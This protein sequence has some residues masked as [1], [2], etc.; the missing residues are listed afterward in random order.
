MLINKLFLENYRLFL[1]KEIYFK[2]NLNFIVGNNSTGKTT[3]LESI[4]FAFSGNLIN[5]YNP[6]NYN[7]KNSVI[8]IDFTFNGVINHLQI[9]LK[10]VN[11]KFDRNIYLNDKKVE[12]LR[13]LRDKFLSPIILN[14][15]DISIPTQDPSKKRSFLD[16]FLKIVDEKF[17]KIYNDLKFLNKQKSSILKKNLEMD[18]LKT[19]NQKI[20]EYS[21]YITYKRIEL[22]YS[23][24]SV[25]NR[26]SKKLL[27]NIT[28]IKIIYEIFSEKVEITNDFNNDFSFDYIKSIYK[29]TFD[30]L[31]HTE[32]DQK[33]I[34][35]SSNKDNFDFLVNDRFFLKDVLSQSGIN[36][37]SLILFLGL[38]KLIKDKLGFYPVLLMDE[39]F[40]FL[41]EDNSLKVINF[42]TNY[43]QIII[44]STKIVKK[45]GVNVIYL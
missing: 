29:K 12:K 21:S 28:N 15:F 8:S 43:P 44:T 39:P 2:E 32:I 33:K 16:K 35:V 27:K 18:I 37:F 5:D 7:Q 14:T 30:E 19:I 1:K 23:V 20:I 6:I 3:I 38:V 13:V 24:Y 42:L 36:M 17:Y 34:I 31:F 4:F 10:L 22:L 45:V 11:D 25:I 41:D 9:I 40:A 26:L